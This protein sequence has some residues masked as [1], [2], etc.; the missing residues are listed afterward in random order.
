MDI[1]V[2]TERL[3]A[4][5]AAAT[6]ETQLEI[7]KIALEDCNKF[8]KVDSGET[9]ASSYRA[10]DFVKGKLVWNTKHTRHAYF[11][12]EADTTKNPLASR[13][14]AHKAAALYTDKWKEFIQIKQSGL[15]HH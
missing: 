10:S 14:W 8:C 3:G 5:I 9:R 2:Q 13:M 7:S 6:R 12:G 1:S 15:C 11:L 4:R